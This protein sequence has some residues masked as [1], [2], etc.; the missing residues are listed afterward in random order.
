MMSLR[1]RDPVDY[2]R[3]V[4]SVF[5]GN[6]P[7][8]STEEQLKDI[9]N[10]VGNVISFRLV[11]DRESG[12]PK[13]YGF[14]EYQDQ[15]TAMSAMRN[16]NGREL[17]GRPLRVDH[18]TSEKNRNN[19]QE[20]VNHFRAMG[21]P[22]ESEYGEPAPSQD[23]PEA[24]SKAVASLPPEQMFELM[25]QMKQCIQN[26]PVEARNMLLQNPQLAYALLQ[27]QVVMR[28]VDPEIAMKMLHRQNPVQ[29]LI[30]AS[31][32][33]RP[34]QDVRPNGS[35]LPGLGGPRDVERPPREP[36]I[37]RGHPMEVGPDRGPPRRMDDMRGIERVPV[38]HAMGEPVDR[39]MDR[40]RPMH[41]EPEG[42]GRGFPPRDERGFPDRG[43]PPPPDRGHSMERG[44]GRSSLERG[45][46]PR[47][48]LI[49]RGGR[50]PMDRPG[51]SPMDRPGMEG[52][53][54]RHPPPP[55]GERS[56]PRRGRAPPAGEE[57]PPPSMDPSAEQDQEK[58]A[59]IMQ[60]LQLT[61]EQIRMLPDEQRR[62]ILALKDQLQGG[63]P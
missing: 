10:E 20:E 26:N 30:P 60:V 37:G 11:F 58:A 14:A 28:I 22:V 61:P 2:E 29:P 6:I 19:F 18:A 45:V 49:D 12:K 59:L 3:S 34:E 52:G 7:Y 42:F 47:E 50:P 44:G 4:R 13:G 41:M 16:L 46:S 51:N 23:A 24:I 27:A 55:G 48:H 1:D 9:F 25:K 32:G 5:V 31:E 38:D 35:P 62:S 54:L 33:P 39:R 63:M 15:E 56:D 8:E 17:H 53:P 36:P 57:P 43:P 40:H 21:P